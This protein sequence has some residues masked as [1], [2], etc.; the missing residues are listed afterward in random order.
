MKRLTLSIAFGL[1]A[2]CIVLLPRPAAADELSTLLRKPVSPAS[3]ATLAPFSKDPRVA[4]RWKEALSDANP[5]VR[6]AAARAIN[7]TGVASLASDLAAALEKEKDAAAAREEIRG[8][9]ILGGGSD[10]AVLSAAARF[11]GAI[12]G[13]VLRA[14]ARARGLGALPLYFSR[15][16]NLLLTEDDHRAFFRIA[17]RGGQQTLTGA[18]AM[19]L[20]R[21]DAQTWKLILALS[22]R[23]SS[24]AASPILRSGLA[25]PDATIR[26]EAAW[27]LA[28]RFAEAKPPEAELA[29]AADSLK[30]GESA[31]VHPSSDVALRFG[32]ELL[33][34]EASRKP[35]ED[36]AFVVVLAARGHGRLGARFE[37]GPL[38]AMLTPAE[39]DAMGRRGPEEATAADLD[40][41]STHWSLSDLPHGLGA[42]FLRSTVCGGGAVIAPYGTAEVAFRPDG[43]PQRVSILSGP[44]QTACDEILKAALLLSLAPADQPTSPETPIHL[45]TIILPSVLSCADEGVRDPDVVR[46]IAQL[47][48][49]LVPPKLVSKTDPIYP[50]LS[51]RDRV[52]G[53]AI[54]VGTITPAGCVQ[55]IHTVQ[56]SGVLSIDIASML[57][58][59]QWRYEPARLNRE[60]ISTPLTVTFTYKLYQ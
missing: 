34:R 33:Y 11:D 41:D 6:G 8:I 29:A 40:V 5:D 12:D 45:Q 31:D 19:A 55:E 28:E 58:F 59:L 23:D 37:H 13:D 25:S 32:S 21:G 10:D 54:L 2:A 44:Q 51:G 3:V 22:A 16:R 53:V 50:N 27:Y 39:R 26:G 9:L 49:L 56:S 60:A 35:V 15:L 57:A 46:N 48:S 18:A 30:S 4:A 1:A 14:F 43:R 38:A 24:L 42:D 20:G 36:P 17:S 47:S 52:T 7:A